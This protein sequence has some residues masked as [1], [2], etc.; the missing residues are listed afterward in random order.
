MSPINAA[1]VSYLSL[2]ESAK[3]TELCTRTLTRAIAAGRLRA[4]R[5]G[6]LVRIAEP[7]LQEFVE[8]KPAGAR[9]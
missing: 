2:D 1:P 7:D 8:R 5:V 3:R 9:S 4:F 6:R